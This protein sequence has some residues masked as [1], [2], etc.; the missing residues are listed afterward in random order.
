MSVTKK[1]LLTI[2]GTALGICALGMF[3]EKFKVKEASTVNIVE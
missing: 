2:I 3:K 1:L